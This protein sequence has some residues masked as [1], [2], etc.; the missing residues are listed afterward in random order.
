M[1]KSTLNYSKEK[2]FDA[3]RKAATSLNL[4]VKNHSLTDGEI[5]LFFNGSFFSYGNKID[6]QIKYSTPSKCILQV[7]SVSAAA[8]QII[9]WGT[10]SDLENGLINEVKNILQV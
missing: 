1:K 10:N 7:S 8:I 4:E 6:V 5:S 3:V 2:I 9:D